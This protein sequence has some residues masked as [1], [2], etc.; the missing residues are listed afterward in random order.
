MVAYT[1][2]I[3]QAK[4]YDLTKQ[5]AA[6]RDICRGASVKMFNL[7]L[8]PLPRTLYAI[9]LLKYTTA[10]LKNVLR[11]CKGFPKASFQKSNT[12]AKTY[13][14]NIPAQVT[15]QTYSSGKRPDI[16]DQT[17]NSGNRPDKH[18]RKQ[19]RHTLQVTN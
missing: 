14:L 1:Q 9:W 8:T 13:P 19:T 6:L 7:S 10:S 15:D 4:K 5:F 17:C 2:K 3:V 18:S 16:P 11:Q 12:F